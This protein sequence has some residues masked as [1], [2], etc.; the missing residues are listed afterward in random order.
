MIHVDIIKPTAALLNLL[1]NCPDIYK[2]N[3]W[4]LQRREL[5]HLLTDRAMNCSARRTAI[6]LA[7]DNDNRMVLVGIFTRRNAI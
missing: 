4:Q 5:T 6:F 2:D 3:N 7:Y 1:F